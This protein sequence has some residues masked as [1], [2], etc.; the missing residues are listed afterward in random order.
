MVKGHQFESRKVALLVHPDM[1]TLTALQNVM[2]Q[3]DVIAIVARD[4]PTALLAMTQ[5][6]FDLAIVASR[7]REEGDGWP[8]AAVLRM[9]F[10]HS[11]LAVVTPHA[12]VLTM[13]SA[14]NCG[15]DEV[16]EGDR[17][18]QEVASDLLAHL[19]N[20]HTAAEDQTVQ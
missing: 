3:N 14:I 19:G 13:K 5:Y 10:P 2:S 18:P 4:L 15:I 6:Y 17:A 1:G 12:D 20:K 8:V 11:L 16:Y 9:I 7:I